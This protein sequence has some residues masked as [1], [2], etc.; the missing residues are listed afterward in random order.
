MDARKRTHMASVLEYIEWF[1]IICLMVVVG[2]EYAMITMLMQQ[3]DQLNERM[4]RTMDD[5]P[6]DHEPESARAW[7]HDPKLGRKL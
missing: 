3:I 2:F 4:F 7:R 6:P 1:I 5:V